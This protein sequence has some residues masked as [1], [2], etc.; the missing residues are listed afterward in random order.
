[1]TVTSSVQDVSYDTD[2]V[3][4]QFPT[5]FY[6][7]NEND[8][9]VDKIAKANG[10][11]DSLTLGT[12]FTVA[13]AGDQNG[14]FVTSLSTYPSGFTLHVYR[15]V[16]VTQE[17]QYQQNDPFPAKTTE[18]A[19]DK[20]TMIAQQNTSQITNSIRYPL[21]EFTADG[22]LPA[23]GERANM[24]LGFDANGFQ[25]M[26]PRPSSIGAGD[27][28]FDVFVAGVDYEKG[29]TTQ[30][31]LSRAPISRANCWTY[32][33]AVP[34]LDFTLADADILFPTPI[35]ADEVVVRTGTTLSVGVPAQQSVG[36]DQLIYGTSLIR[37]VDSIAQ[38]KALDTTRYRRAKASGYYAAGDGGAGGT[39]VWNAADTT[40]ENG[41]TVIASNASVGGR[42]NL[43]TQ[44][45]YS[46]AQAGVKGDDVADDTAQTQLALSG[47]VPAIYV[48]TASVAYKLTSTITMDQ[49][50][51]VLGAGCVPYVNVSGVGVNTRGP[52]AWFHIA[53][54][55]RGFY[56]TNNAT[57]YITGVAFKGIGTVR[58]HPTPNG[59]ATYT[60]TA[61]DWDFYFH[62][63]T[64]CG[65]DDVVT[66]NPYQGVIQTGD[67]GNGGRFTVRG[68]KGQPFKTGLFIDVSEDTNRILDC[69]F[70]PMWSLAGGVKTFTVNT[71]ASI[72]LA[73]CDNAKIERCFSI[74][75]SVGL[76]ITSNATGTVGKLQTTDLDFDLGNIGILVDNTVVGASGQFVNTTMQGYGSDGLGTIGVEIAGQSCNLTFTNLDAQNHQSNALLINGSTNFVKVAGFRSG[77]ANMAGGNAAVFVVA[78]NSLFM[79]TRPEIS[80]NNGGAMFGGAGTFYLPKE[81]GIFS[82]ATDASG[83]ITI[84]TQTTGLS[85]TNAIV[86]QNGLGSASFCPV[87]SYGPGGFINLKVLKQDGTPLASSAVSL[88]YLASWGN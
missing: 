53:H 69:H 30:L 9:R 71:R 85:P 70:W 43:A 82:G 27:L 18:K 31:T 62:N 24:M 79:E 29:V 17:T 45:L 8:I 73:R 10:A 20:L 67:G 61:H 75:H 15:E 6:F 83:Q 52:G 23:S 22:T 47:I 28:R 1:M 3:T 25:E 77:F 68:L 32:W 54:T 49:P 34:Q 36:D 7:L 2:G 37:N 4:T 80:S 16:P 55:G 40:D 38:L 11:L 81:G 51:A 46:L 21:S 84:P 63:S 12:D 74:Y 87:V 60:P 72:K 35:E 64:D 59:D 26:V 41:F 57:P 65:L 50:V 88:S 86:S 56:V 66:L 19:L 78:S 14:G 5:T 58:D 48:S 44:A 39:Y 42:W 13:G 76:L 33:D